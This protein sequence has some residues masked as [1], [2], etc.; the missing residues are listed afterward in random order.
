MGN[1]ENNFTILD[2][3]LKKYTLFT[4][5]FLFD[6]FPTVTVSVSLFHVGYDSSTTNG[7]MR[8]INELTN[9]TDRESIAIR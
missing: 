8:K 1:Q 4:S 2:E 9:L 3:K 6:A 5:W 7:Y